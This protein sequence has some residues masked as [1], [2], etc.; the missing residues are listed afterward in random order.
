MKTEIFKQSDG[1]EVVYKVSESGTYYHEK[2]T[3]FVIEILER[4]RYRGLRIRLY[5]GDAETGIDWNEENDIMG[6][7]GRSTGT[8]KIPLLIATKR[9]MGGGGIL[10][11]CIVKIKETDGHVLYQHP[12]YDRGEITLIPNE[13]KEYPFAVSVRGNLYSRHKTE[14]AANLLI[15]KLS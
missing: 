3:D 1:K 12:K 7:I 14:K 15:K 8:V 2:T 11:H 13:D 5:Y 9:S 10:D 6:R 4:I